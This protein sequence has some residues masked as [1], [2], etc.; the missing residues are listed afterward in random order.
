[1]AKKNCPDGSRWDI[2]IK[3]CLPINNIEPKPTTEQ[4]LPAAAERTNTNPPPQSPALWI[5]VSMVTLGSMLALAVW[6]IIYRRHTRPRRASGPAQQPLQ[7][8]EKEHALPVESNGQAEGA[9]GA[10]SLCRH[11]HLG[12]QTG[13]RSEEG[14]TACRDPI[15][16]VGR[17][18][19]E[20]LPTCSAVR[21]HTIP[22]PATELGGTALVTTKT[23]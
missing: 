19:S 15:K 20:G 7:K 1:M 18:G 23:V 17:G 21:E 8:T 14:F 6:F 16:H 9:A 13:F 12:V 3:Y 2:L 10:S 22:L 4:P 5:Y 11:L